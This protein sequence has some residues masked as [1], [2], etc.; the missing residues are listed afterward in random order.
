MYRIKGDVLFLQ[1]DVLRV[2]TTV[3]STEYFYESQTSSR[4]PLEYS[5]DSCVYILSV[6]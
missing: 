4:D 2:V 6:L 1:R 5:G 3:F